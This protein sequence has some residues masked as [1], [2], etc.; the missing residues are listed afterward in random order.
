MNWSD[1]MK[2]AADVA[3]RD[4][5]SNRA[6]AMPD[7][8]SISWDPHEVWLTRIKQPRERAARRAMDSPVT[9]A[10]GS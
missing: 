1:A 3:A 10:L 2:D 5:E 4:G 6:R 8:T 7:T 9:K